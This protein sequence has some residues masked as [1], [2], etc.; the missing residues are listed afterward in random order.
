MNIRTDVVDCEAQVVTCSREVIGSS[1]FKVR[2]RADERAF[3]RQR[4]L[5]FGRVMLLILQKTIRSVQL[6]LNDFF[7]QLEGAEWADSVSGS[8]WTQARAKLRHTAFIELND[9]AILEP[10]YGGQTD[11]YVKRWRGWRV[12]AIDGSLVRLPNEEVLG[13]EFGWVECHNQ[14]G[15]CGRYVQGRLSSLFDVLNQIA[16][17][18]VLVNWHQGERE[19]GL[20]HLA[21]VQTDD[22]VLTDRGYASYRWI[23]WFVRL[24]RQ[25]PLQVNRAVGFHAIKTHA[26]SL[27]LSRQPVEEVLDKLEKLFGQKPVGVR[28]DNTRPRKKLS[29]WLAYQYQRYRRKAV[30]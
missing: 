30:F 28:Q 7:Q 3:V 10:V 1:E 29:G 23:A 9:R 15:P 21:R 12:L 6:H 14:S 18:A 27:L 16:L 19:V 13:Q 2:H 25:A 24:Q 26:I 4:K 11:F 20:R 22:L 5:S 17:E 8:A